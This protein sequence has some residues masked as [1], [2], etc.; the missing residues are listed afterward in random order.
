MEVYLYIAKDKYSKDYIKYNL[1]ED[2][3]IEINEFNTI[4]IEIISDVKLDSENIN[5]I[6]GATTIGLEERFL[7]LND[8]YYYQLKD[9]DINSILI[10]SKT[11]K[12]FKEY[13]INGFVVKFSQLFLNEL[14]YTKPIIK[15]GENIVEL[16][17]IYISSPKISDE[18]FEIIIK[19]LMFNSYFDFNILYKNH[20]KTDYS[21]LQNSQLES[22]KLLYNKVKNITENI[23]N[24][25]IESIRRHSKS[26]AVDTYT[27]QSTIDDTSFSWLMNNLDV[28]EKGN[29]DNPNALKIKSKNCNINSVLQEINVENFDSYEN[30]VIL[31]YAQLYVSLLVE[32]KKDVNSSIL[33]TRI[34][35]FSSYLTNKFKEYICFYI[36]EI[37]SCFLFVVNF[38]KNELS[39]IEPI[40]EFPQKIDSF[41]TLPHYKNYFELILIYRDLFSKEFDSSFKSNLEIESFDKLFESYLLY[42]IKDTLSLSIG[43]DKK[44]DFQLNEDDNNKLSGKYTLEVESDLS[45][46]IHYEDIP[47]EFIQY[48]STV[49][50][51]DYNPDYIIEF[52]YKNYKEFIILDAK[53]KKYSSK[54]F[55]QDI[56]SLTLKYLHKIGVNGANNKIIGLYI[57]SI[58]DV[59]KYNRLFKSEYDILTSSSP[60]LPCIGGVEISP[61]NLN[62]HQ[63]IL[64]KIILKHFSLFK[65]Q[66]IN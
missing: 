8:K 11:N 32:L 46:I 21:D 10:N 3:N 54:Y 58:N 36:E 66:N 19:Y 30:K 52:K 23:G 2:D 48:S 65:K 37:Q 29:S 7:F 50:K 14:G 9:E 57:L 42:V 44:F 13:H 12:S 31:G 38:F 24:F 61:V 22:L 1:L 15:N 53:Y 43:L 5:F 63:N 55:K 60:V 47:E 16:N 49:K 34:G 41:L 51:Y 6:L 40:I 35:S 26:Y 39:V 45:I 20:L 56:E 28:L 17:N 33:R 62:I 4:Y 64:S 27:S 25:K 59:I 18:N